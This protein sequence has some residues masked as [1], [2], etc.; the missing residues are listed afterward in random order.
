MTM[1][2][3][4]P[5]IE[6][7]VLLYRRG[8]IHL[9]KVHEKRCRTYKHRN[10]LHCETIRRAYFI[11]KRGK[12]GNLYSQWTLV[13]SGIFLGMP[14]AW[15]KSLRILTDFLWSGTTATDPHREEAKWQQPHYLLK[16]TTWARVRMIEFAICHQDRRTGVSIPRHVPYIATSAFN[17]TADGH[18]LKLHQLAHLDA[19]VSL[20]GTH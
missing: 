6:E 9:I 14:P 5:S 1:Y 4:E 17:L 20:S 11:T 8:C 12:K 10:I 15:H 3:C 2:F 16:R 18:P 19:K 13:K 7:L